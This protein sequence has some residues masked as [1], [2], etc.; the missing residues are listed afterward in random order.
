MG[1]G[2]TYL[3]LQKHKRVHKDTNNRVTGCQECGAVTGINGVIGNE[4]VGRP[5]VMGQEG[6]VCVRRDLDEAFEE[7]GEAV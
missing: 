4:Q 6:T 1:P 3:L 5:V 2:G 7:L